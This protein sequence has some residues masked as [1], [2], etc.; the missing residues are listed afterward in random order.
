[1]LLA[2]LLQVLSYEICD[3][4]I[5]EREITSNY[6]RCHDCGEK[7]KNANTLETNF[8]SFSKENNEGDD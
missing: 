7:H 2:R 5:L 3:H 1:M 8:Y 4:E 6:I